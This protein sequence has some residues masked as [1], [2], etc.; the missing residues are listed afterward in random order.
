MTKYCKKCGKDKDL[1]LFSKCNL[2]KD[3][4]QGSCKSCKL[5]AQRSARSTEAGRA[6]DV[7]YKKSILG[8]E[9]ARNHMRDY[10][11]NNP[12][13]VYIYNTVR[14]AIRDGKLVKGVCEVCGSVNVHAHHDD[15]NHILKVRWLCV[16]HHNE[17]HE[18]NTP[19]Y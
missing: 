11:E 12:K 2:A 19:A 7:R 4:L 9:T 5:E 16:K 13:L 17:W 10:R 15:Y 3:G 18:H 8:R 1:S 6:K 14:N